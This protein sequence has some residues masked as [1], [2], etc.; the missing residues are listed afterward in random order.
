[1]H[2]M[3]NDQR[4]WLEM[5]GLPQIDYVIGS[6]IVSAHFIWEEIKMFHKQRIW[7]DLHQNRIK[8]I[9]EMMNLEK[10]FDNMLRELN[11]L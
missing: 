6:K 9:I 8:T 2:V 4:N 5:H 10:N 1:M 7:L 3:V 11:D